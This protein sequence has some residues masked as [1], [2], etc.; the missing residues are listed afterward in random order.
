MIQPESKIQVIRKQKWS[1]FHKSAIKIL[2]IHFHNM[3][4]TKKYNYDRIH[5]N[6]K[7]S[8]CIW[9][10]RSLTPIGRIQIVKSLGLTNFNMCARAWEP[11]M[12]S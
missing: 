1:D 2:G 8:F 9:K 10:A 4:F 6:L 12:I 7:T 11:V 5:Q 3:E